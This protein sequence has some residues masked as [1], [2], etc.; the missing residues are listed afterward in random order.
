MHKESDI[1]YE[2]SPAFVLKKRDGFEVCLSGFIHAIKV[3]DAESLDKATQYADR[4]ALYPER[5][6]KAFNHN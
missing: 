3:C 1:V 5:Y 6:R 2:N 4:V